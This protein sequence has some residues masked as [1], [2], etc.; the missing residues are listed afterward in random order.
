MLNIV[1]A[2]LSRWKRLNL[3]LLSQYFQKSK[4]LQLGLRFC[5]GIRYLAH[6]TKN[7]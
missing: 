6:Q 4:R 5:L 1:M 7:E 3:L 2:Y